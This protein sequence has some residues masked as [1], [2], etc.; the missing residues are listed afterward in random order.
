MDRQVV[1]KILL[2]RP[3]LFLSRSDSLETKLVW[4]R[5]G[6]GLEESDIGR[7]IRDFPYVLRQELI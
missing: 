4:L 6:L 5:E 2:R 3:Q 1:G 7:V